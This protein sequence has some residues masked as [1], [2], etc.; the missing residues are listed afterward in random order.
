[1][2]APTGSRA[3]QNSECT[4][5]N[6]YRK[7]AAPSGVVFF[8][9]VRNCFCVRSYW[10][11]HNEIE[12]MFDMVK[13][14]VSGYVGDTRNEA[15]KILAELNSKIRGKC[16]S[17]VCRQDWFCELNGRIHALGWLTLLESMKAKKIGG[18][19][20]LDCRLKLVDPESEEVRNYI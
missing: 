5:G 7:R 3:P 16:F 9:C 8:L 13:K 12:R 11:M 15:E 2:E 4:V 20:I 17:K 18:E 1:M 19:R 6:C 14:E 10:W